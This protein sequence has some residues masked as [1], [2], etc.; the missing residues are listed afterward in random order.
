LVKAGIK[1]LS[2]LF[3][4]SDEVTDAAKT[5]A[6]NKKVGKEGEEIATEN[7]KKEF[8]GDNVLEQVTGKFDDGTT[9]RMDNVV[10][11][12]K[13]GR[14]KLVNETK[15]GN[16]K[17]SSQQERLHNKGESVKLVGGNAK[18]AKGQVVNNKNTA[19]RTS[20]VDVETKKIEIE[21]Q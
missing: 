8:E 14:A 21:K 9:T 11:D 12:S 5:L 4:K 18:N 3:G 6:K 17:L 20:R 10:V 13:T 7:L 15:T 2:K 19:T 16:A 1:A